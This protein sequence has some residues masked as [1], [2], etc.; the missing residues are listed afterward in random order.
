MVSQVRAIAGIGYSR[1]PLNLRAA[2]EGQEMAEIGDGVTGNVDVLSLNFKVSRDIHS[3]KAC[4][5]SDPFLVVGDTRDG[6]LLYCGMRNR[7]LVASEG[8]IRKRKSNNA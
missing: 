1:H 4:Q 7:E 5:P 8:K 6:G 3:V 2:S